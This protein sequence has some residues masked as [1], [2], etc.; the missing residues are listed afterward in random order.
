MQRLILLSVF[1]TIYRKGK[2]TLSDLRITKTAK[3]GEE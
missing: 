3:K 1:R 2:F